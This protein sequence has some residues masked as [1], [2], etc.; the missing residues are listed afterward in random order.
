[1]KKVSSIQRYQTEKAII[2]AL[3]KIS[4]IIKK[5]TKANPHSKTTTG[6]G[7]KKQQRNEIYD[8][9]L[10]S[11]S[12]TLRSYA[13]SS[14][15]R[16]LNCNRAPIILWNSRPHDKVYHSFRQDRGLGDLDK[17]Y[18]SISKRRRISDDYRDREATYKYHHYDISSSD[19]QHRTKSSRHHAKRKLSGSNNSRQ[20]KCQCHTSYDNNEYSASDC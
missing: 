9:P 3:L 20:I 5:T 16:P 13:M 1:M 19:N 10:P 4:E 14:S 6:D 17:R 12:R 18:Y 2:D 7:D 8:A 11:S 15:Q